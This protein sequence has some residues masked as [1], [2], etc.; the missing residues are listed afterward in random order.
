MKTLGRTE[1]H[2]IVE[3]QTGDAW[4]DDG[5]WEAETYLTSRHHGANLADVAHA[6][7]PGSLRNQRGYIFQILDHPPSAVLRAFDQVRQ[8]ELD[9]QQSRSAAA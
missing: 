1:L 2:R 4:S 5:R 8:T 3:R 7:G 9:Y 6:L